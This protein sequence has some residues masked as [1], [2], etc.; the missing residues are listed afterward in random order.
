MSIKHPKM[1]CVMYSKVYF[2][3]YSYSK[4]SVVK[5]SA[6]IRIIQCCKLSNLIY[7][8]KTADCMAVKACDK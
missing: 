7:P 1:M 5:T 8:S 3:I 4:H 2:I 6:K